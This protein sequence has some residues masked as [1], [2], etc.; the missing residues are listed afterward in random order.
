MLTNDTVV[1]MMVVV[2]SLSIAALGLN[3]RESRFCASYIKIETVCY[4]FQILSLLPQPDCCVE[5]RWL[6]VYGRIRLKFL[7][8]RKNLE[9]DH[10]KWITLNNSL[11]LN[12]PQSLKCDWS[13]F[14]KIYRAQNTAI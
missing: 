6:I 11:S 4:K 10:V 8:C 3:K 13:F 7:L 9:K 14:E 5:H 2:S 12:H 1:L